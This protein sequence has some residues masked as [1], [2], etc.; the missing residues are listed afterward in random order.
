MKR[1]AVFG[2]IVS[3]AAACLGEADRPAAKTHEVQLNGHTFTLPDG[4]ETVLGR[5]NA[6][7]VYRKADG[8][9]RIIHTHWSFTRPQLAT[10]RAP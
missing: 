10:P 1:L 2:V 7:E 9:W 3:L 8:A 5:W 6:T 4:F